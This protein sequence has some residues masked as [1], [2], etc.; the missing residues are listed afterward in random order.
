MVHEPGF[1]TGLKT[2]LVW[3][4]TLAYFDSDDSKKFYKIEIK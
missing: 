4:N 2:V 1:A 3:T